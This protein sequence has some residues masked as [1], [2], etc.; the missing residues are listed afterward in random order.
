MKILA[1]TLFGL[2]LCGPVLADSPRH[3]H[4]RDRYD[5]HHAD[6]GE[7][8][9]HRSARRYHQR[10]DR[11]HSR[12]HVRDHQRY[13][14]HHYRHYRRSVHSYRH[15]RYRAHRYRHG[16]GFYGSRYGYGYLSL[17]Y[18]DPHAGGISIRIPLD[19]ATRPAGLVW[20]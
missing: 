14:R 3:G 1:M 2:V 4:D 8:F 16:Y 13:D 5:R 18:F 11:R 9:D 6:H 7:R 10:Y 12:R 15:G 19:Q 17:S 20:R